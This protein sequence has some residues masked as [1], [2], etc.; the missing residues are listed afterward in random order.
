[1]LYKSSFKELKGKLKTRWL[2]PYEIDQIFD[3]GF[4]WIVTIDQTRAPLLVKGHILKM[5]KRALI[6]HEFISTLQIKKKN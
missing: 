6:K 3:N 4:I 1:L 5:Y 2:G